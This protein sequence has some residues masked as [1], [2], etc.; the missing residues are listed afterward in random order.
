MGSSGTVSKGAA[1]RPAR[2]RAAFGDFVAPFCLVAGGVLWALSPLGI[3]LSEIGFKTPNVFWKLFPSAPLLLGLGLLLLL[4]TGRDDAGRLG[5]LAAGAAL[6]GV[7][8]IVA[9][10]VGLFYLRL[11]DRYIMVAPAYRAFRLGLLVLAAGSLAFGLAALRDRSWP[12]L[13]GLPLVA[14]ATLG[15]VGFAADLGS[16]GAALWMLFGAGWAWAGLAL[17]WTAVRERLRRRAQPR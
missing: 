5:K 12:V 14:G 1:G 13:A 3:R 10:D 15:L 6:L 16:T 4:V 7:L 11:D 17:S 9:G 8:L 2:L